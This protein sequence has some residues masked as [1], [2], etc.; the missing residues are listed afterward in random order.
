MDSMDAS[1][2][3]TPLDPDETDGLRPTWVTTREDLNRVEAAGI[4]NALGQS[5]WYRMSRS[6]LL[7]DLELRKLHRAMFQDVWSWAGKYRTTERNIGIRPDAISVAVVD[8][9]ED[10]AL[11]FDDG[12][13]DEHGARLHHR[14]VSIH[15][16]PNGNGR[17]AR[18]FT[19][20]VLLSSGAPAFTWGS[21][22]SSDDV[23]QRY[24]QALR[25]ADAGNLDALIEFVR[26]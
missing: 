26:S 11:W 15:P 2:G 1:A 10:C 16:F 7:D 17:H 20:L 23:R 25:R 21:G 8:L 22:S 14:L 3:A 5:R 24:L 18:A 13:T 4:A 6:R 9:L 19:D 12:P